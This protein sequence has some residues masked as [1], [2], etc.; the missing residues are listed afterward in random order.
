MA[1]SSIFEAQDTLVQAIVSGR[2]RLLFLFDVAEEI[3]L[4]ALNAAVDDPGK[5]EG[6]VPT[7]RLAQPWIEFERP[8]VVE[9]LAP[10]HAE[11][12]SLWDV[13]V[14][15]Y[16]FGVITVELKAAFDLCWAELVAS[17]AECTG[18]IGLD[19]QA[20]EIAR[21]CFER[22][23]AALMK[24]YDH[25]T[26]EDYAVIEIRSVQLPTGRVTT[27]RELI[28]TYG[29]RIA[30]ILRGELVELSE[31]EVAHI[32]Q[33]RMSYHPTDLIVAGWEAAVVFDSP[34]GAGPTLTLVEQAN[35][36]LLELKHYDDVLTRLL[37][38]VYGSL[39]KRSGFLARWRLAREAERL[40]T[41][42]LD[43][44]ELTERIDNSTKFLSDSYSTRLYRM[45]SARLGVPDY[46]KL[47][48]D[49]LR[50]AADLH[51]F[52]TD[53]FHQGSAFILELMIV[54]ILIIDLVYLFWPRS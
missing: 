26:S 9:L 23:H 15:Y 44:R 6:A 19:R 7:P 27:S 22:A 4:D 46:R 50:I 29:A 35:I 30:Q 10:Q 43:V 49:K 34:A 51:R 54:I 28:E 12:G 48:D 42:R 38:D 20:A 33:S 31:E 1:T 14:K 16:E 47:V 18:G 21:R 39:E 40:G 24:P 52:M 17:S 36:Q 8:P 41:M 11:D 5:R 32:L 45:V 37:S 25:F 3:D 53:R 13:L 2:F